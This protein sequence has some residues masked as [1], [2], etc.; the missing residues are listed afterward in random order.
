MKPEVLHSQ[1]TAMIPD[2][3][4]IVITNVYHNTFAFTAHFADGSWLSCIHAVWREPR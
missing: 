4:E 2:A 3:R 1:L